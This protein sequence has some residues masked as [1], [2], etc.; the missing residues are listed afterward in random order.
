MA[1]KFIICTSNCKSLTR[2]ERIKGGWGCVCCNNHFVPV[3]SRISAKRKKVLAL[4]A[5]AGL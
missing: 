3:K 4:L 5:A 2:H 1:H